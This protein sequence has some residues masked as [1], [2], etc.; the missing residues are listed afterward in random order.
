MK[1]I[2]SMEERYAHG[3]RV[4]PVRVV[5]EGNIGL[6]RTNQREYGKVRIKRGDKL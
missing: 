5:L 3:F 2:V 4:T 1:S 6:Y